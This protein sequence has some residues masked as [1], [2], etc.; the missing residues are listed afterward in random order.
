MYKISGGLISSSENTG[1]LIISAAD[2]P[3]IY[4]ILI[5][6]YC[7][8]HCGKCHYDIHARGEIEFCPFCNASL[9]W[10]RIIHFD[11]RVCE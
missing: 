3:T 11:C 9:D 8:A 6:G 7:K 4:P 10:S 2:L 5:W 1:K